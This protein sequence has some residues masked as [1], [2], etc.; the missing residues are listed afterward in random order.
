MR[1]WLTINIGASYDIFTPFTE[2]HGFLSNFDPATQQLLVPAQGLKF[3]QSIGANI[4]GIVASSPTAGVRTS[5]SKI[6]PRVGFAA[7]IAANTVLRG[8]YSI[9][10]QLHVKRFPEERAIQRCVL[11]QYQRNPMPVSAG[12]PD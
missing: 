10:R 9:A 2:V 4:A 5:C 3:L 12:L 1:P 6:A 8:G 11:S 7:A